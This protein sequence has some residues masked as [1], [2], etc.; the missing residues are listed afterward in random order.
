M[1]PHVRV[2]GASGQLCRCGLQLGHGRTDC[3][4]FLALHFVEPAFACQFSEII[5]A[6]FHF[7]FNGA[8]KLLSGC[9]HPLVGLV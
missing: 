4:Q 6:V 1:Q 8:V 2:F 3:I 7:F 9:F 5:G